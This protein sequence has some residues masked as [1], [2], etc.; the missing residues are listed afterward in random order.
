MYSRC[1]CVVFLHMCHI[2]FVVSVCVSFLRAILKRDWD[3]CR[4]LSGHWGLCKCDCVCSCVCV[5]VGCHFI[6]V[7]EYIVWV[8]ETRRY[9][10]VLLCVWCALCTCTNIQYQQS[11]PSLC[12]YPLCV[13]RCSVLLWP[14]CHL[15]KHTHTET[16][17]NQPSTLQWNALQRCLGTWTCVRV[18]LWRRT[19]VWPDDKIIHR[20]R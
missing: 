2:V 9:V 11:Q 7:C 14:L 15:L 19:N 12:R 4:G 16:H 6:A 20:L 1:V 17:P 13:Q 18:V 3:M 8:Y 10:S 5:S